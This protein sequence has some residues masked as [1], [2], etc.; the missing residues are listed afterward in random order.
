MI[1][2]ILDLTG[3]H[4]VIFGGGTVG[5]RKAA[6]FCHEARVTVV[7]RSFLPAIVSSGAECIEAD[8]DAM[9]DRT[10]LDLLDGAFLAVA[11]TPDAAL[12]DRIGR[13]AQEA[14]AHFN[15]AHGKTGD[16][17]VPSVLRGERYLIAVSTGGTSPAVP[18]FLRE[19]LEETFP[20]LDAMIGVEG[21]LR[22]D[23]KKSVPAQAD[24]SRI[25]RAVLHDPEAWAWLA[26]GE[27]EAYRKIKERYIS[28]NTSL[29]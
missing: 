15:N 10:L 16:V 18:R 14:G 26:G 29:C 25:L 12:N 19:H 27:D 17:L 6:Y 24:R 9:D 23:L 22:E 28:G 7:S 5:A 21:R 11:A 3:R 20:S 8:V 2:L 4:V 1:P 13:L